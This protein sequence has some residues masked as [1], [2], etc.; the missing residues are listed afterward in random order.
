[1]TSASA[2]MMAAPVMTA[3]TAAPIMTAASAPV[4]YVVPAT[5]GGD[6]FTQL[7]ANGDGQLSPEEFAALQAVRSR[8]WEIPKRSRG[9]FQRQI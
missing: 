3:G 4:Q 1:M 2:P 6:L 5:Q 8:P 9:E 7:D